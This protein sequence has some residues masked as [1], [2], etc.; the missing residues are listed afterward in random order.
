MNYAAAVL[1]AACLALGWLYKNSLEDLAAKENELASLKEA[2]VR[3]EREKVITDRIVL[4]Y[5]RDRSKLNAQRASAL[6]ELENACKADDACDWAD[7][8]IPDS[9]W[10]ALSRNSDGG[11]R[12]S[13]RTAGGLPGGG[14]SQGTDK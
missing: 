2:H 11:S 12:S 6:E 8:V 1:L 5:E 14:T 7:S 3:L 9:V 10:E 13:V 4:D